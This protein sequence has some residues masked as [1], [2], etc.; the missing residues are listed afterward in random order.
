MFLQEIAKSERCAFAKG[1]LDR[2][3]TLQECRK[4]S[5]DALIDPIYV[6]AQIIFVPR[7]TNQ[8]GYFQNT[9]RFMTV[10]DNDKEME[11]ALVETGMAEKFKA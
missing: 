2:R 8:A 1:S 6:D 11:A 9:Q 3:R 5:E 4:S 10:L 7:S